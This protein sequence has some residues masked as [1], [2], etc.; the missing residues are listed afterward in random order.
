VIAAFG[1][2]AAVLLPPLAVLAVAA[3]RRERAA[4]RE[5]HRLTRRPR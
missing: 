1:W 2:S 4:A 3:L 5:L